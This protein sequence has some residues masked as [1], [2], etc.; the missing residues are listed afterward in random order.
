M[1][2]MSSRSWRHART[3]KPRPSGIWSY[4][5]SYERG[6]WPAVPGMDWTAP[7]RMC[8]WAG[9][10]TTRSTSSKIPSECPAAPVYLDP[11]CTSR[12]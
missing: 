11:R 2:R 3:S 5:A 6:D 4:C 10:P 12:P 1:S 7:N 8:L 9:I